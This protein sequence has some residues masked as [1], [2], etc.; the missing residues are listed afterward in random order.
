MK[1]ITLLSIIIVGIAIS[2]FTVLSEKNAAIVNQEQGLYIFIQSK[3]VTEYNYLGTVK[4]SIAWTGQPEEMLNSL[5]KKVK[6]EHPTA[7]GIIFTSA[8]MDKADAVKFK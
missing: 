7:D 2:A 6:K 8:D 3:P 5:I 1:K 4:K